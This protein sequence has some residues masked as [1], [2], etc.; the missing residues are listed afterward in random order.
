MV[1]VVH[2]GGKNIKD[3]LESVPEKTPEGREF[4]DEEAIVATIK[5][6]S[7]WYDVII[8]HA[9]RHRRH[10]TIYLG[11]LGSMF[12]KQVATS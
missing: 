2:W 1:S 5:A 10:V 3:A 12:G 8:V 9:R 11:D 4:T 6:L 7:S